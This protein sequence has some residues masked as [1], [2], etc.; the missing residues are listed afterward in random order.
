VYAVKT[1]KFSDSIQLI[2][3]A[4]K[5]VNRNH[6]MSLHIETIQPNEEVVTNII[7]SLQ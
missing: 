6:T 2:S 5:S 1:S 4:L 3:E 7:I